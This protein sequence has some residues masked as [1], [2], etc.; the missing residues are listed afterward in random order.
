MIRHTYPA[1]DPNVL[2]YRRQRENGLTEVH[3]RSIVDGP[4]GERLETSPVG[5]PPNLP[6]NAQFFDPNEGMKGLA[7]PCANCGKNRYT[8]PAGPMGAVG[9]A[10]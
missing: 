6:R 3:R 7:K 5:L 1:P 4:D 8:A 9:A 10:K 2:F